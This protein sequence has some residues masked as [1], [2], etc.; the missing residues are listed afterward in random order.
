MSGSRAEA[1]VTAKQLAAFRQLVAAMEALRTAYD[2]VRAAFPG[3]DGDDAKA[4]G[5]YVW[6]KLARAAWARAADRKDMQ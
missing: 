2:A 5:R 3:K 4:W 1:P 6:P